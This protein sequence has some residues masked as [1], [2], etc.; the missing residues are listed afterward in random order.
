MVKEKVPVTCIAFFLTF[1]KQCK[2]KIESLQ[3]A[4]QPKIPVR[5]SKQAYYD[6]I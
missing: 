5:V 3:T 2:Q 6:Y 4:R 1:D